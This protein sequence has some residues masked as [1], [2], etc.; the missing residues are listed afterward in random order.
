MDDSHLG[1]MAQAGF[2]FDEVGCLTTSQR[3]RAGNAYEFQYWFYELQRTHLYFSASEVF[4]CIIERFEGLKR[5]T[6]KRYGKQLFSAD[7]PQQ[8]LCND[9]SR[10]VA[11]E[12]SKHVV[13]AQI[14]ANGSSVVLQLGIGS[15]FTAQHEDK[16]P[17]RVV[18]DPSQFSF[19][20]QDVKYQAKPFGLPAQQIGATIER[21]RLLDGG[22]FYPK[23]IAYNPA[24]CLLKINQVFVR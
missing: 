23:C 9:F 7:E 1:S 11:T 8:D 13:L 20:P 6:R 17:V 15:N 5:L 18:L 21:V 16:T 4:L 3:L 2:I 19:A 24:R 14:A 12:M 10:N 22:R